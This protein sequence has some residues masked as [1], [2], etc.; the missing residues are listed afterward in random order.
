MKLSKIAL[1]IGA[2]ALAG[3]GRNAFGPDLV[4]PSA[5][6]GLYTSTGDNYIELFWNENP[7]PDVSG[8]NV[9]VSS[10]YNGKYNLIGSTRRPY[11]EDSDAKN[12]NMYYYAVTAYDFDGNESALSKDVVYD[13]P[14]PEGYNVLLGEAYH[15]P[16]TSGYD[17]SAY[18]IVPYDDQYADMYFEYYNDDYY[19]A[20]K[21]DSDIE[22]MGPTSSILDIKVAPASGWS[23]THDAV[24][25]VG[26]TYVVWTWDDHYA[27]FRVTALSPSRVVFDWAYQTRPSTTL[28]KKVPAERTA[29]A[30]TLAGRYE[31]THETPPALHRFCC[32]HR[33]GDGAFCSDATHGR[34]DAGRSTSR[35]KHFISVAR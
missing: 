15:F 14:R 9:Y 4:P 12:G 16:S 35:V 25:R 34:N 6:R 24:L 21:T 5:P 7:E 19:M 8:Y 18:A 32:P 13:I 3:C 30:E 17:F 33:I 23:S 26:H 10:T 28:L 11:Y 1:L 22:D 20:V 27:K 2:L 31:D 29:F